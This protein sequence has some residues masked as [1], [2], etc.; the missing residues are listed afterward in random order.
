[1]SP[2]PDQLVVPGPGFGFSDGAAETSS[3]LGSSLA[4]RLA[5]PCSLVFGPALI[6]GLD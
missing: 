6:V 3:R 4:A 1:M 2:H 5:S